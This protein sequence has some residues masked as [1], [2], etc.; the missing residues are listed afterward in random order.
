M[1]F[2]ITVILLFFNDIL[3]SSDPPQ[4]LL[5]SERFKSAIINTLF[6]HWGYFLFIILFPIALLFFELFFE[7]K[8]KFFSYL[9]HKDKENKWEIDYQTKKRQ[10]SLKKI[11]KDT[12]PNWTS[13]IIQS[14]E[15]KAFIKLVAGC[16]EAKGFL[17]KYPSSIDKNTKDIFFLHQSDSNLPF[18][19]IKCRAI[20]DDLVSLNS[21]KV[22]YDLSKQYGLKNLALVTTGGFVDNDAF[23]NRRG[24]NLIGAPQLIS[25]L[26]QLPMDDQTYLF[27]EMLIDKNNT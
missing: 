16:F 3:I 5:I 19:V 20:G 13:E 9:R 18:A 1:D 22:V 27:A 6:E 26:S 8:I 4:P 14:L 21:L 23:Q 7:R 17:I 10:E 11:I 2:D 12:V 24:F 25:L 15:S